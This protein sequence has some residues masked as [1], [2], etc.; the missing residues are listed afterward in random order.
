MW[1]VHAPTGGRRIFQDMETFTSLESVGSMW[2]PW[3]VRR[4]DRSVLIRSIELEYEHARALQVAEVIE[5]PA[6]HAGLELPT[7]HGPHGSW[8]HVDGI[9]HWRDRLDRD[10]PVGPFPAWSTNEGLILR[11]GCHRSCALYELRPEAF[12]LYLEVTPAPAG[13][14]EALARLR[15]FWG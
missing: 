7:A 11:D 10:R 2:L 14:V 15:Q 13:A 9:A 3:Y 5:D 6:I 12:Q 4:D 1:L 8:S